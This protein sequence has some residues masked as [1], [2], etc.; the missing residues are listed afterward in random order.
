MARRRRPRIDDDTACANPGVGFDACDPATALDLAAAGGMPFLAR[1]LKTA[2][3]CPLGH[4][5][6]L[7][8]GAL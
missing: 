5:F 1:L 8:V 7:F 2:A 6:G 3:R 4:P